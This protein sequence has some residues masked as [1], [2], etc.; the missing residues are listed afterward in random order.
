VLD[1]ADMLRAVHN[2]KLTAE[3][4][5]LV[6]H[7]G[8]G[9]LALPHQLPGH[10]VLELLHEARYLHNMD[11]GLIDAAVQ[12]A[13]EVEDAIWAHE[14]NG[15]VHGDLHFENVLVMNGVIVSLLDFEWSRPAPKEVD[16]DV[17]A[18]FC[19]DP[20]VHVGGNYPVRKEDYKDVLRWVH[21]GYPELFDAD[22][23]A[24]RLMLCALSFEVPWLLRMPPTGPLHTHPRQHPLNQLKDLLDYG[25]HA[26]RLG[27]QPLD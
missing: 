13:E 26:E 21:D 16:I 7:E 10:R 22:N 24:D 2:T 25:T 11:R 17:L 12:K 15:L 9:L 1:L 14:R 3:Q 8:D 23:L 6:F 19:A 5:E 4:E 18:R 20:S 27:W